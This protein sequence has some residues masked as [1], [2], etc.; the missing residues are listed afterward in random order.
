MVKV[1]GFKNV[2]KKTKYFIDEYDSKNVKKK[3]FYLTL[4]IVHTVHTHGEHLWI[5]IIN[6]YNTLQD[7]IANINTFA[8][9]LSRATSHHMF[10]HYQYHARFSEL[11]LY[12]V[13]LLKALPYYLIGYYLT[14]N[15][16]VN[17]HN[18]VFTGVDNINITIE[19]A[20]QQA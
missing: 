9:F 10:G 13:R 11:L 6:Y 2:L 7:V 8:L 19:D 3:A 20:E 12:R 14:R 4:K 1:A 17:G 5:C 15:Y 16:K 18:F